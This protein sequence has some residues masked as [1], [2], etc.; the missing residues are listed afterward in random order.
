MIFTEILYLFEYKP[1]IPYVEQMHW[2]HTLLI[3]LVLTNFGVIIVFY[4]LIV[5][6]IAPKSRPTKLLREYSS[7]PNLNLHRSCLWYPHHAR[8]GSHQDTN[9]ASLSFAS[10]YCFGKPFF[11]HMGFR[12]TKA[13]GYKRWC[14]VMGMCGHLD[15]SGGSVR[16]QSSGR[17]EIKYAKVEGIPR[18]I[19]RE[20]PKPVN[21]E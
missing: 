4:S 20:E 9:E 16:D 15:L 12:S 17:T 6:T 10:N 14:I 21:D 3:L 7:Q 11:T 5:I 8:K 19:G 2:H 1:P 13:M 18:S